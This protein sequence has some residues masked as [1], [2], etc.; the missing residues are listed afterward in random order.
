M[1]I[2]AS[3]IVTIAIS[4][5]VVDGQKSTSTI[6]LVRDPDP[7]G[8]FIVAVAHAPLAVTPAP[9]KLKVVTVVD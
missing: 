6:P 1:V 5:S 7:P 8:I 3:D 9:V 2:D 4:S